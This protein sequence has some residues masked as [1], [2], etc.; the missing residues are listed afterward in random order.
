MSICKG[1]YLAFLFVSQP[2]IALP[3]WRLEDEGHPLYSVISTIYFNDSSLLKMHSFCVYESLS[4]LIMHI[5]LMLL[6]CVYECLSYLI[7]HNIIIERAV[8]HSIIHIIIVHD[9][10]V[11]PLL[12]RP[13]N[14]SISLSFSVFVKLQSYPKL[15]LAGRIVQYYLFDNINRSPHAVPFS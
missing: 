6:F 4:Y 14:T 8:T 11:R 7:M 10:T 9:F 12:K 5:I 2:I 13:D 1:L 15:L 3:W